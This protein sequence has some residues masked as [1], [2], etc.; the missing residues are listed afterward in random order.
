MIPTPKDLYGRRV[1]ASI[2]SLLLT[3]HDAA[4]YASADSPERITKLISDL[5]DIEGASGNLRGILFE[6]LSGYLARRTAAS[7][8]M[9]VKA[10]DRE[11]G[12]T[13]D[14]DILS[15]SHQASHCVAIEC[16]GRRPGGTVTLE[17]VQDWVR[18]LPIFTS[19]LRGQSHL[20]ESQIQFE[21]W[22]SGTFEPDALKL[23]ENEKARR[24]KNP[25]SWKDGD[26]VLQLALAGREKA[27]T[28][29]LREHFLKHPLV[30]LVPP[31]PPAAA[32][33]SNHMEIA[34]NSALFK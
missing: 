25:I 8:D 29:A 17:E 33:A 14:I 6:L 7:I 20:R 2:S 26:A 1:A 34:S 21:L 18:H 3:L 30:A 31:P 13:A 12:K 16:K 24:V 28:N 22:T 4:A 27:I 19:H 23:L 9:G 5:A 10:T 32:S 15:F 11:S